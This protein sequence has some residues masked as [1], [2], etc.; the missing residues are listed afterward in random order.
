MPRGERGNDGHQDGLRM[1]AIPGAIAAPDF[2]IDNGRA[3]RLLAGGPRPANAG[4]G[5]FA[6]R[7]RL[8]LRR[9]SPP[10]PGTKAQCGRRSL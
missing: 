5:L 7:R 9:G 2:A 4:S 10:S 3:N 8:P 6:H 1:D